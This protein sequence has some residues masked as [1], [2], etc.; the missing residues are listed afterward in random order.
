LVNP[1]DISVFKQGPNPV[2]AGSSVTY[3]I[4]V[5]NNGPADATGVV[6]TD[7]LP[8]GFQLGSVTPAQGTCA[9][10]SAA[11]SCQIGDVAAN[12]STTVAVTLIA[13]GGGVATNV[14]SVKANE[15][16]P[17]PTN[18]T[19]GILT[20]VNN[21]NLSI[22]QTAAPNPVLAGQNLKY[23]ITVR[24]NGPS[25]ATGVRVTDLLPDGA[26]FVSAAPSTGT[27]A[28]NAAVICDLGTLSKGGTA[29]VTVTVTL[30]VPG[31]NTNV[32][33]VIGNELDLDLGNNDQALG[34]SVGIADLSI[35]KTAPSPSALVNTNLTYTIVVK[36]NGPSDATAVT[37]TDNP[38]LS[39]SALIQFASAT[40]SQGQCAA[41]TSGSLTVKCSIGKV[42]VGG[43]ATVT[44]VLKPTNLGTLTNFARVDNSVEGDPNSSNNSVNPA[45]QT[46]VITNDPAQTTDLAI[47]WSV[48]PE[49]VFVGQTATFTA[50]ITNN[51]P[52]NAT[53]VTLKTTESLNG[54]F[55]QLTPLQIQAS[56]GSCTVTVTNFATCALGTLLAGGS[57]TVALSNTILSTGPSKLSN[58]ASV[59]GDQLDPVVANDTQITRTL[60]VNPTVA[61]L[62]ISGSV[63]PSPAVVGQDVQYT[64]VVSNNGPGA[65]KEVFIDGG[66]LLPT[67]LANISATTTRG[68]CFPFSNSIRV[69]LNCSLVTFADPPMAQGD[70]ITITVVGKAV[71]AGTVSV[72]P[73]VQG[74]FNFD[75]NSA[76]D[77]VTIKLDI[78]P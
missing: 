9:V 72:S 70:T 22:T 46:P 32:V 40:P 62:S 38:N 51:G 18:N 6:V 35:T 24:N 68:S 58:S 74:G 60:L 57:A 49:P 1:A 52:A 11:L 78:N 37:I 13:S 29:T 71:A 16:D 56:Q 67:P 3:T 34:T 5:N 50:T 14:A 48:S 28:F 59:T 53:G 7:F 19:V 2:T 25:I 77:T 26:N 27:C 76:N 47:T 20:Y 36:N 33:R 21:T 66:F 30:S 55:V 4:S 31:N 54:G 61:D 42:V 43:T 41:T 73:I 15:P 10:S 8:T 39:R 63:Q 45:V 75:S 69:S 12:T 65:V 23:T 44:L 64:F 17:N